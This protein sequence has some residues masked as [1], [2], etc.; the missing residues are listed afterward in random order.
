MQQTQVREPTDEEYEGFL[1]MNPRILTTGRESLDLLLGMALIAWVFGFQPLRLGLRTW[2]YVV[3]LTMIIGPAFILHELAHKYMAIRYGK[4]AR[5]ALIR[6]MA[7]FT[8]FAGLLGIP[9]AGPGA[10]MILGRSTE[11]ESGIFSAAGPATNFVLASLSYILFLTAPAIDIPSISQTLPWIFIL[12]TFIN[13]VLGVFNLLPFG[14]LD[15]AKIMNWNFRL[16]VLLIALN[17]PMIY[18]SAPLVLG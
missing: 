17:A 11:R 8:F 1:R 5:F 6:Q 18:L 12:S 3:V 7:A 16:W 14:S 15:G 9:I 4:Y 13:G 2:Q 10:T